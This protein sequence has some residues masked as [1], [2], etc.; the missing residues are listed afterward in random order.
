MPRPT[1]DL[2]ENMVEMVKIVAPRASCFYP[3]NNYETEMKRMRAQHPV[4][5]PKI[6]TDLMN[7]AHDM[8]N[9][10]AS[11]GSLFLKAEGSFD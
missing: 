1:V 6:E 9:E 11:I 8:T 5:G 2:S 10:T 7:F 3:F 4:R